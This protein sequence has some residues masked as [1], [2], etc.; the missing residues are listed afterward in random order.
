MMNKAVQGKC[1]RTNYDDKSTNE[2]LKDV[3]G[4][5][6]EGDIRLRKRDMKLFEK[7]RGCSYW[8]ES[9]DERTC[10]DIC[11]DETKHTKMEFHALHTRENRR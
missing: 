3:K 11:D 6:Y 7:C 5:V 2:E 4:A 8:I 1:Y 9:S 10:C